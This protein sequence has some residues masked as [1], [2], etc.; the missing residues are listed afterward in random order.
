VGSSHFVSSRLV[1]HGKFGSE[2]ILGHKSTEIDLPEFEFR[3]L[4]RG[5]YLEYKPD[6]LPGSNA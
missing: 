3:W 4:T 1:F 2:D 5:K 6:D